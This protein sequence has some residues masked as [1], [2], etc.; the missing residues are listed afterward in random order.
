M[1]APTPTPVEA[2]L[3]DKDGTL[4][5]FSATWDAW[6]ERVIQKLSGG[7]GVLA[8]RLAG[9]IRYDLL[10]SRFQ[11]DSPVIAG[12][13]REAAECLAAVLPGRTASELE[14]FLLAEAASAPLAETVALVPFLAG[15]AARD[16]ALGVMTNDSET[17]ARE[18]LAA[19][20]VLGM[21]DFVAGADSGYGAKPDPAPLLAFAD[22]TGHDPARIVMVG[23]ST[24]DLRAGRAAGMQ[25]VGVLTGLAPESE[26]APFADAVL[27]DIG[28]L[29][30]WI[31]R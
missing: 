24:H 7:D 12:T 1:S 16:Y 31:D 20:G 18:H 2:V 14:L 25:C 23:D 8:L 26:L 10:E 3:F 30:G 19:V 17:V 5:S 28:H 6:A 15:L 21:F 9:S 22:I 27:P 4:F 29:P 11:P 13:N